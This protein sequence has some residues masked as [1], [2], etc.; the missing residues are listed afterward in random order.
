M[1]V[2]IWERSGQSAEC[3]SGVRYG[4]VVIRVLRRLA[5]TS[6]VRYGVYGIGYRVLRRL[7]C[8][9]GVRVVRPLDV[10]G[11]DSAPH[12]HAEVHFR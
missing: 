8:M 7:A 4:E 12:G 11:Y 5:C 1:C 9:S 2:E 6:G 3:T 10:F